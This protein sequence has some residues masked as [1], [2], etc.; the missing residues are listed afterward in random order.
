MPLVERTADLLEP[1]LANAE[2]GMGGTG[3]GGEDSLGV[4]GGELDR[5]VHLVDVRL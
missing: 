5:R 1:G 2:A 3:G 4:G